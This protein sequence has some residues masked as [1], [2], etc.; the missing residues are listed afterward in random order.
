VALSPKLL[1]LNF[2][3]FSCPYEILDKFLLTTIA[4]NHSQEVLRLFLSQYKVELNSRG[5]G[6]VNF[7]EGWLTREMT[8]AAVWNTIFGDAF[9]LVKNK[10]GGQPSSVAAGL[11]LG[12]CAARF[13]GEWSLQLEQPVQL[14]WDNWLLPPANWISFSSD[15]KRASIDLR[16]DGTSS[17]VEFLHTEDGWQGDG[18]EDLPRF[19]S[20]HSKITILPA[21]AY[22]IKGFAELPCTRFANVESVIVQ[23]CQQ[24]INLLKEY[25]PIYQ[26]WVLDI[27]RQVI[28]L[29]PESERIRSGSSKDNL[30]LIYMSYHRNPMAMAEM[31]VHEASH[32]YLHLL[33]RIGPIADGKDT[34]LYYSPVVKTERTLDRILV[35]YHAFANVLLLYR[36]CRANGVADEGYC[37][38]NEE[39]VLP[40]LEQ[41][42]APLRNNPALTPLGRALFEPLFE[43]LH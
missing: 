36:L 5:S 27:I 25:A 1:E 39:M 10:G 20:Q 37:L 19:G 12:V 17:L 3:G 29:P 18:A 6:L 33:C 16:L 9:K 30:G 43:R 22:A 2:Q 40:D 11:A 21:R 4:T 42:E 31:L 28:L 38:R 35:A 34:N 7:L 14:L 15:G 32:L 8:F 13:P 24:I 41:L 26:S 23:G